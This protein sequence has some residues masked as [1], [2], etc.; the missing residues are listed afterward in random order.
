MCEQALS[1]LRLFA[2]S[3]KRLLANYF[4]Q[5]LFYFSHHEKAKDYSSLGRAQHWYYRSYRY[6]FCSSLNSMR[7]H[8]CNQISLHNNVFKSFLEDKIIITIVLIMF[9]FIR[10]QNNNFITNLI[11]FFSFSFFILLSLTITDLT[12]N[13]LSTGF[14]TTTTFTTASSSTLQSKMTLIRNTRAQF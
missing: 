14:A 2:G 9:Y 4:V 5:H 1:G 10:F 8:N 12:S 6:E 13:T 3:A 11:A 7:L